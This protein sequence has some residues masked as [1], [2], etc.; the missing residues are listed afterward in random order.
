MNRARVKLLLVS[1]AVLCLAS[2]VVFLEVQAS[3][4]SD[5]QISDSSVWTPSPDGLK[6]IQQTCASQPSNYSQCFIEQM[7]NFGASAD[8]VAF[9]R[10]YAEQNH[11][12]IAFLQEFRPVDMVDVGYAFFPNGADF[13]QRWLL[14]NGAPAVINVD[15]FHFL[16]LAEMRKDPVYA[17]LLKRDP[18]IT[19]FDGDRSFDAAPAAGNLPGGEQ[20]FEIDYPLKDRCRA[21]AQVGSATY[22]FEFDPTGKLAGVKFV[23]VTPATSDPQKTR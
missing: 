5:E 2:Y 13:N 7:P 11:G 15:D 12:L 18:Q 20:W 14:L 9:T 22:R 8:A 16:P 10:G 21:C 3:D 19:L 1:L 6:Q 17:A 4:D 23:K